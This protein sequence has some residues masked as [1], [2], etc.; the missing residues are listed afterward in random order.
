MAR[1]DFPFF[2]FA[3]FEIGGVQ[4]ESVLGYLPTLE[5]RGFQ[6]VT[7]LLAGEHKISLVREMGRGG[8]RPEEILVPG[9]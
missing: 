4:V 6:G 3:V 9:T 5:R 1:S 7:P 8:G 2:F